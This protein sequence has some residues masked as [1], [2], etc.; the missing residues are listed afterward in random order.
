MP[1]LL[2][3]KNSYDGA[4]MTTEGFVLGHSFFSDL[5]SPRFAMESIMEQGTLDL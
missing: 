4:S 2:F 5:S 1:H 3:L